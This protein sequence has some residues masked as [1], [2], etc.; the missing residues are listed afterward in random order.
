[1]TAEVRT[2]GMPEWLQ[3]LLELHEDAAEGNLRVERER[4]EDAGITIV[5][6]KY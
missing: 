4:V 2:G 3:L 6:R 5:A 1:M